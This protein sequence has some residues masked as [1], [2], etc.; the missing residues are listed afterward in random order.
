MAASKQAAPAPKKGAGGGGGGGGG[1]NAKVVM[2]AVGIAVISSLSSFVAIRLAMPQQV[3]VEKHIKYENGKE[4][5]GDK[6]D[7]KKAEVR[8]EIYPIGDF[9]VNLSDPG[10]HYLKTTVSLAMAEEGKAEAKKGG[11]EGEG[12][13]KDP[14]A[15][16]KAEMAPF[17]PIYKDVINT[18]LSHETIAKLQSPTGRDLLKDEIKVGL[19]KAVPAKK[20]MGVYFQEFVIQ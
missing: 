19:N 1:L 17:E 3:I 7:D 20:V 14:S 5:S 2:A 16:I 12:G 11:G 9:I 18:T 10:R 15:A 6:K 13:G 8:T 4:V